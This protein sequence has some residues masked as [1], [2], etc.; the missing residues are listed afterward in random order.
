MG[1]GQQELAVSL[2]RQCAANGGWLCLKNLH[3]VI[4]WLPQLE[5]VGSSILTFVLHR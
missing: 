1:Q 2:L 3:L 4:A 5:K